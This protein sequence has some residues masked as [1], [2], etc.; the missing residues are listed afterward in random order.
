MP[1]T[2]SILHT[3]ASLPHA[4]LSTS[5]LHTK[6]VLVVEVVTDVVVLVVDDVDVLVVE[7]ELVP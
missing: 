6:G 7:L 4:S 5:P 2:P 3:L 1:I